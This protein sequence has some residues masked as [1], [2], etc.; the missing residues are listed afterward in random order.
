MEDIYAQAAQILDFLREIEFVVSGL[1]QRFAFFFQADRTFWEDLATDKANHAALVGELKST[2]LKN[3]SPLEVGMAN[4]PAFGACRHAAQ[5]QLNRLERGQLGRKSALFIARDFE[6]MML[7]H[8]FYES[9]R[10]EN[11]DYVLIRDRIRN[12]TELHLQKLEN[13]I[14]TLFP[15]K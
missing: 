14:A 10:S 11:P 5:A 3:G 7:E 15:L 8:R 13:Y 12:E 1:Y 2:L 4:L 6:K 9:I